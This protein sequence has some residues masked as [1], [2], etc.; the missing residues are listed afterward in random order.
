MRICGEL[1][2]GPVLATGQSKRPRTVHS[3]RFL[4]PTDLAFSGT[5]VIA[6]L[7]LLLAAPRARE[8]YRVRWTSP[9]AVRIC[10]ISRA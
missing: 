3:H 2:T 6:W 9:I 5:L 1:A 8:C 4:P 7:G 10:T